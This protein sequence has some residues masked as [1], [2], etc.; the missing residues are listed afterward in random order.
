RVH[1]HLAAL[2]AAHRG[3][4]SHAVRALHARGNAGPDRR[5]LS[6]VLCELT[7][8]PQLPAWPRYRAMSAARRAPAPRLALPRSFLGE[9]AGISR[10]AGGRRCHRRPESVRSLPFVSQARPPCPAVG[11]RGELPM[12]LSSIAPIRFTPAAKSLTLHGF[13]ARGRAHDA[14]LPTSRPSAATCFERD[15]ARAAAT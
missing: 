9:S 11:T 3:L 6:A 7:A 14:R 4:R 13:Q 8:R 2:C 15:R 10:A 5:A 1:R 12:A